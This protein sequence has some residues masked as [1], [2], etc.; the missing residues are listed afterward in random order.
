MS[1]L[2]NLFPLSV[3]KNLVGLDL[4]ERDKLIELILNMEKN[5][6]KNLDKKE[7]HSWLGDINGHENLQLNSQFDKLFDLIVYNIKK[8]IELMHIDYEQ[9]DIYIQRSWAT[10]SRGVENIP[11]HKHYQSHISF[12]YYLKKNENDSKISFHDFAKQNEFIPLLFSSK[13]LAKKDI[14]KKRDFLSSPIVQISANEDE[15]IIFPS[16]SSHSTEPGGSNEERISISA[17]ISFLAKNSE[18]LEHLTPPIKNWKK[19]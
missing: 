6:L 15:I 19:F 5:S 17:D 10:I 2:I 12:A 3:Y 11:P 7:G 13:S 8:Y 1:Q 18:G 4:E 9:L 16:K 14:I